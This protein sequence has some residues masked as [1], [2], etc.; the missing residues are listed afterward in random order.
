M[1]PASFARISLPAQLLLG[2]DCLGPGSP[3]RDTESV[4]MSSERLKRISSALK[5]EIDKGNIPAPW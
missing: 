3:E 2:R 4:G 1:S 5:A